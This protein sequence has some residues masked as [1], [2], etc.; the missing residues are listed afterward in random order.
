MNF[1]AT[2]RTTTM[3]MAMMMLFCSQRLTPMTKRV[4]AGSCAPSSI[5][6]NMTS[7]FGTMK[8]MRKM[9]MPMAM[10]STMAG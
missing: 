10:V 8:I 7:N 4:T 6:V 9:V 2:T 3:T 5:S 1:M